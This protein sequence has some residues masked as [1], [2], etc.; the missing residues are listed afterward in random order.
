MLLESIEVT[1]AV[2]Q[3]ETVRDAACRNEHVDSAAHGDA[4][5]TKSAEV[6]CGL[7]SQVRAAN[8]DLV[9]CLL[10]TSPSPRD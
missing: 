6:S 9:D 5:R 7:D 10:Y 3:A 4:E 8:V 2:K 1:V